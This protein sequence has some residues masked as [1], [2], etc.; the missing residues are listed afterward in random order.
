MAFYTLVVKLGTKEGE[1]LEKVCELS[2]FSS[3]RLLHCGKNEYEKYSN[4]SFEMSIFNV[5]LLV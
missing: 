3:S 2:D 4:R 1:I 5:Q